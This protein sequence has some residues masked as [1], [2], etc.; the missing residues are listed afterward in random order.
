MSASLRRLFTSLLTLCNPKHPKFLWDKFKVYMFDDYVHQ[1][2][3]KEIAELRALEDISSILESLGK[4]INDY[5]MV[6]FNVNID[7]TERLRRMVE[8]ETTNFDIEGRLACATTLNKEQQFAYDII[9]EKVKSESSG[10]F[11]IDGLGGTGKTFVYKAFLTGVR[12]QNLIAVAITSS[13][14]SASLLPGGRT[15]YSR[16]KIHLETVAEISCSVSK[17][18]TLG[19]L[20]K[21]PRLIIWDEAPMVNHFAVESVDKMLRDI[22]DCNLLFGGKVI[23]FGGDFRQILPVVPKGK[24]RHNES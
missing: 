19:N 17:Q 22:T 21:M 16:F 20:L 13:G 4:N 6:P 7:E 9:M 23:V 12:S 18:S 24:K 11:F 5:A 2:V 14:V 15:A 10:A 3:P 1:N 8:E